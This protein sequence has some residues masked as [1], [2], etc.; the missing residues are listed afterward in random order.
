M[1]TKLCRAI[2][3][4]F[5]NSLCAQGRVG[6]NHPGLEVDLGVGLW[7]WPMPMDWDGDGDLD[8]IVSCP[9]APYNGTYFFE[10][11]GGDKKMPVFEKQVRLGDALKNAQVSYVDG[12][13][14]VMTGSGGEV[15]ALQMYEDFLGKGFDRKSGTELPRIELGEGMTRAKQW[16]AVDYDGDGVMDLV[17][18]VGYW[19]DYGWDN[20]YDSMGGWTKGPLRGWVYVFRN[21]GTN[22]VPAYEPGFRVRA[23]GEDVDVYGM[24]SPNFADYDGDGDLDLICGEFFDGFTWFENEGSRTKPVYK[25]GVY[26]KHEGEKIA[27]HVQ[28]ITPVAIDWD[29]DGDVDLVVGDEDGRVALVENTG[30]IE[31]GIPAFLPPAYFQQKAGDLKFGALVTPVSVDW[32]GDGDED[33]VCGNTSGNIGLIENLDGGN[34]PKWAA[35][36]LLEAD[37]EVIHVQAGE[38]GS[39]QGPAEAKWGYTTLDVADWN[40]DGTL[41]LVVNDIRGKVTVFEGTGTGKSNKL[42]KARPIKVA[43][44]GKPPKPEWN[45][46]NPGPGE[47][48]TQWR[49]TPC[50]VDWNKDGLN[51]LIV[52]DTEGYL[53]FFKREKREGE[54]VLLPGKRV[55]KLV[56]DKMDEKFQPTEKGGLLRLTKSIAGASGRRKLCF[57]DWDGDGDLDLFANSINADFYENVGEKDGITDFK[58]LGKIGPKKL[59]GHTTSPTTVDWDKDG[60]LDLLIGAEDGRFYHFPNP[61]RASDPAPK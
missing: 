44:T 33:L 50:V 6:F 16:K 8:L 1:N 40:H 26:L 41:D 55:F 25:A 42:A 2:T 12:Q 27:M 7:A 22:E 34:P 56:S 3:V 29:R 47:L 49:T 37:G 48:A 17:H 57:A 9:D 30:K 24:P 11:P 54:L 10:N 4:L 59:A 58:Y 31:G 20:A 21:K 35:P 28:M 43:W 53:A 45:W 15:P 61:R 46:W 60:I 23:G 38:N 19:G 51:D 14:R 39:I 18:G 5:A 13:P 32:D 36:V 52:L